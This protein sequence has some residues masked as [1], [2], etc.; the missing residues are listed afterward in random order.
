VITARQRLESALS[1]LRGK[2][3]TADDEFGGHRPLVETF[4]T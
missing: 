3:L 1:V 2:G 4:G